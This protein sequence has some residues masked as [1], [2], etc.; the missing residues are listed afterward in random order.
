MSPSTVVAAGGISLSAGF[1]AT[2]DAPA[3]VFGWL[4]VITPLAS[5]VQ[6]LHAVCAPAAAPGPALPVVKGLATAFIER[7]AAR[8]VVVADVESVDDRCYGIGYR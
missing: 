5:G 3:V 1:S 7:V 8:S 4:A 2:R 6:P